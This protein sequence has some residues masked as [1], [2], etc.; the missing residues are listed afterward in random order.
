MLHR[1]PCPGHSDRLAHVRW[2]A[3]GTGAG[4]STVARLLAGLYDVDVLDGDRAEHAWV[5]RA[6]Q[7]R[8]PHLH[9]AAGRAPGERWADRSPEEVFRSTVPRYGNPPSRLR[10]APGH[11]PV[12]GCPRSSPRP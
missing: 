12:A 2:I 10:S 3:G 11:R 1:H 8:H 7:D 6:S 5:A 4:K 9:A